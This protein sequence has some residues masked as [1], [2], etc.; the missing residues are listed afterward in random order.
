MKT[1]RQLWMEGR[2]AKVRG[3]AWRLTPSVGMKTMHLMRDVK[4]K[5]YFGLGGMKGG[6]WR[7]ISI[8]RPIDAVAEEAS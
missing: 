6:G 8:D 5:S 3:H 4:V 1:L 7:T 2:K